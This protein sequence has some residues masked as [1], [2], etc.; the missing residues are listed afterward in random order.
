MITCY[1]LRFTDYTQWFCMIECMYLYRCFFTVVVLFF[2]FS[3]KWMKYKADISQLK[4]TL[5]N[6]SLL[7]YTIWFWMSH[8]LMALPLS[9]VKEE[10]DLTSVK[11]DLPC[12][13]KTTWI[14]VV[15][16]RPY[17]HSR[18]FFVVYITAVNLA[19]DVNSNVVL[20]YLLN[21]IKKQWNSQPDGIFIL[22]EMLT[23]PT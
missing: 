19:P 18:E 6:S 13:L 3:W 16:C 1:L 14:D 8:F 11:M 17:H 22:A 23:M 9:V 7:K 4:E 5:R 15:K 20:G 21:A 12:P 2:N 10:V